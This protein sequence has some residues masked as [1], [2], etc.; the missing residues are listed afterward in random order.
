MLYKIF[1][2]VLNPILRIFFKIKIHGNNKLQEGRLVICA[3]HKSNWDPIILGIAVN[4]QVFYFAKKE[5][6]ENKLLGKLITGLGAFP[7][8]RDAID[9]HSIKKAIG[10][11]N[12]EKVLGIF[13]EGTRVNETD[14]SNMKEGISFIALKG[15]A[16]IQPVYIETNYKFRGE[17]NIYFRDP[18]SIENYLSL[19]KKEAKRKLGQDVFN[20]IYY[21]S[22]EIGDK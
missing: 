22:K 12:D 7:V 16:D 5:L 15:K 20:E 13:P 3:N 19:P 18:I 14:M 10:I 6:F 2:L 1:W 17:L 21:D 4:R 9:I 11:L 8:D